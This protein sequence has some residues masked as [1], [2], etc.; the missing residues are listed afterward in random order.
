MDFTD[1]LDQL[2]PNHQLLITWVLSSGIRLRYA[3]AMKSHLSILATVRSIPMKSRI[4]AVATTEEEAFR[5]IKVNNPGLLI[6]SD[7]LE[8]GN[9][10]SLCSRALKV[11][12]DLKVLM[13]LTSKEVDVDRALKSGALAVVCDDDFLSPE[14]EVMQSLLAA[15]NDKC[16]VSGR[17]RSRMKTPALIGETPDSLTPREKD[18]LIL[19]L[20]GASDSEIAEKLQISLYT[21][22]E[23]GKSIR[24]KYQVK[25]RI[26]LISSLLGRALS[27]SSKT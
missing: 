7:Q 17:A 3:I 8:E 6:C 27:Q 14:L 23:Y 11:V 15:V 2:E 10:F 12:G 16:Y 4:K 9:G 21:V 5:R 19:L 18:V 13:V 22:K 1:R 24:S 26:Q 20:K 25:T